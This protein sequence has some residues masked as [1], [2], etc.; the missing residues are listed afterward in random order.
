MSR[1]PRMSSGWRTADAASGAATKRGGCRPNVS[2][3]AEE[4]HRDETKE[5]LHRPASK[6]LSTFKLLSVVVKPRGGLCRASP[7]LFTVDSG[8]GA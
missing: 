6:R 1:A 7:S 5:R 8:S 2:A 3:R 4:V